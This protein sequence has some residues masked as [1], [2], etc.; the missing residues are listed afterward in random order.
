MWPH[1]TCYIILGRGRGSTPWLGQISSCPL[2]PAPPTLSAPPR[3]KDETESSKYGNKVA[4]FCKATLFYQSP[5]SLWDLPEIKFADVRSQTF[6]KGHFL[7]TFVENI[8][9]KSSMMQPWWGVSNGEK[10][11]PWICTGIFLGAS[12]THR[13]NL[14]LQCRRNYSLILLKYRFYFYL[15]MT[16]PT[17]QIMAV[18]HIIGYSQMPRGGGVP[19]CGG[20]RRGKEVWEE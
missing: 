11:L 14:F 3:G 19:R 9:F 8:L 13:P 16:R 1:W 5:N 20:P 15:G 18:K 10:K 2:G 7:S 12:G 17:D 6:S 4:L